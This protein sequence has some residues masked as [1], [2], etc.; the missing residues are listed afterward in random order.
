M[1]S[2]RKAIPNFLHLFFEY[3]KI[4]PVIRD[5]PCFLPQNWVDEP[6]V[7]GSNPYPLQDL[8]RLHWIP[9][10]SDEQGTPRAVMTPDQGQRFFRWETPVLRKRSI[11]AFSG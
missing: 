4:K 7:Q 1:R 9:P 10:R 6:P 2:R 11:A 5:H 8:W 3:W